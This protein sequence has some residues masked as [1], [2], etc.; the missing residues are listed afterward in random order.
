MPVSG[1]WLL[2]LALPVLAALCYHPPNH[3][4]P[5]PCR[6]LQ[7]VPGSVAVQ[8]GLG[9]ADDLS[10]EVTDTA[11]AAVCVSSLTLIEPAESV[12][13][14]TLLFNGRERWHW[15]MPAS[16]RAD[17]NDT[18]AFSESDSVQPRGQARIDICH[19]NTDST[20]IGVPVDLRGRHFVFR[21]SDSSMVS[22]DTPQAPHGTLHLVDGSVGCCRGSGPWDNLLFEVVN[23]GPAEVALDSIAFL[24]SSSSGFCESLIIDNNLRWNWSQPDL[25]RAGRN[26][27][28]VM[29]QPALIPSQGRTQIELLCFNS[30]STGPG[31]PVD[32]RDEHIGLRFD[33]GS[34]VSFDVP[35]EEPGPLRL[36]SGSD[37]ALLGSSGV[38]NNLTFVVINTDSN[39][40]YPSAFTFLSAPD[41]AYCES[42]LVATRS[43]WNWSP[44]LT[45]RA[46]RHSTLHFSEPETVPGY[47]MLRINLDNFMSSPIDPA[48]GV[49][50]T[51]MRFALRFS[52]G[53][54]VQL[55]P[56]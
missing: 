27:V 29:S 52:D 9:V 28:L 11:S 12:Y 41:T 48:H 6:V 4:N 46:G 51:G 34:L 5:E 21:F 55:R 24:D 44:P 2:P 15:D 54:L 45:P 23:D 7:L 38:R 14:E 36:I 31:T 1:R 43:R 10:F 37:V 16:P 39:A 18:L 13:C 32:L 49:D 47:G 42:L 3:P 56:L 8:P 22:F 35:E 30:D 20:D 26:R 17:R 19:F 53:S 50:I 33:D 25:P 40:A